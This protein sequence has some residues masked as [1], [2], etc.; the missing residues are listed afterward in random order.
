MNGRE[1]FCSADPDDFVPE[2]ISD[3][4][5]RTA[6]AETATHSTNWALLF[7]LRRTTD[8][9]YMFSNNFHTANFSL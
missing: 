1:V 2:L 7:P 6:K 4:K 5:S 8:I 9:T 3:S